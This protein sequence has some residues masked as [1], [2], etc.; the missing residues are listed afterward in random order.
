MMF[1]VIRHRYII[2]KLSKENIMSSEEEKLR[3][4]L[5]KARRLNSQLVDKLKEAEAEEIAKKN[6]NFL[7]LYKQELI[8]LRALTTKDPMAMTLLFLLV[9][10][11]NKQNAI[12]MSQKT[13]MQITAKSRPT[14]SRAVKTLKE[15]KFLQVVKIG[16]ANAYVVNS[17]VFWQAG[18]NGK[19]AV[20]N[21]TVVASG[22]EQTKNYIE[23]WQNVK[24]K[25]VPMFNE[26]VI[27]APENKEEQQKLDLGD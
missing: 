24:L 11:M 5:S 14:I 6:Q 22:D 13:M 10:K 27:E 15:S 2:K 23:N 21:A 9:E 20:F 16:S 8:E 18:V 12:V 17:K 4:E 26:Q 1:H 19:F 3:K 7:Q 25:H